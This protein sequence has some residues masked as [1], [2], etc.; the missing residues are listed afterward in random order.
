M[1]AARKAVSKL[2]RKADS[3]RGFVNSLQIFAP[4]APAAWTNRTVSGISTMRLR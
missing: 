1:P 3:V 2:T 4:P